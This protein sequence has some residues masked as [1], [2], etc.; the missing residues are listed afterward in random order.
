[1]SRAFDSKYPLGGMGDFGP[2]Q[3]TFQS[4]ISKMFNDS[5]P[6]TKIALQ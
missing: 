3:W 2:F 1:M 6:Y 5:W 4:K